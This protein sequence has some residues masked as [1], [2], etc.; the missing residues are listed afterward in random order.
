M[1]KIEQQCFIGFKTTWRNRMVL[2]PIKHV[3]RDFCS[4]SK[5]FLVKRVSIEFKTIMF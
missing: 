1:F 2:D 4:A 5:T 3:L